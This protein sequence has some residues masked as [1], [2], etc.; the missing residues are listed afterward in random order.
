MCDP[1]ILQWNANGVASRK[2]VGELQRLI[3]EYN[4]MCICLQH[5]GQENI[6][7]NNYQ[8]VSTNMKTDNELGSAILVHNSVTYDVIPVTT[9]MF[10]YSATAIDVPGEG[11]LHIGNIYNQPNFN[12]NFSELNQIIKSIPNPKIV[13][14]DFNCHS[15]QWDPGCQEADRKGKKLEEIMKDNNLTCINEEE[16]Y[17]FFSK[18]HGSKTSVDVSWCSSTVCEKVEWNV[19]D[20]LYESDHYPIIITL[21]NAQEQEQIKSQ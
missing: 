8:L 6:K 17:T 19:A 2:R 18:I 9:H 12:Y 21:L 4:P 5:V 10:Q 20:D 3:T 1:Y 16:T 7:I 15:P 11:K 13:V 14:G